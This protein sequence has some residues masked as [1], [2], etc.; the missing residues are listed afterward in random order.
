MQ[1]TDT[2]VMQWICVYTYKQELTKLHFLLC[3]IRY[4][5]FVTVVVISVSAWHVQ[6]VT[7]YAFWAVYQSNPV[8]SRSVQH[9]DEYDRC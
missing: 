5:V 6:A 3:F 9:F 8:Y 4:F 1:K 7:V 2:L